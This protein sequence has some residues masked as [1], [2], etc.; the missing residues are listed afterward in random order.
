MKIKKEN[1]VFI[2]F[3]YLFIL[4]SANYILPLITLPYL[5]RV[6]GPQKF[7]LIAFS[8]SF[9]AYFQILTDYSFNLSATREIS[10]NK[11]NKEKISDIFSY[12]MITKFFLILISFTLMSLIVFM[13]KKFSEDWVVYYFTFGTVIG[14]A[15]FPTWFFQGME[16]MKYITFLNILSK[17]IFTVFIFIFVKKTSDYIYVPLISSLGFLVAGIL[18]IWIIFNNFNIKLKVND[19]GKIKYHLKEGWHL[20]VSILAGNLYTQGTVLIL[21]L[22]ST[23]EIVGYYTIAEKISRAV[24]NISQPVS[25]SIYPYITRMVNE[26]IEQFKLFYKKVF[27]YSLIFFGFVSLLLL[28]FSKNIYIIITSY[29]NNIGISS[30][31]ILAVVTFLISLNVIITPF[32]LALRQDKII[33]RMYVTVGLSFVFVCFLI[34]YLFSAIGTAISL[35]LVELSIFIGTLKIIR[36]GLSYERT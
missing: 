21:G 5:I 29:S 10:I 31:R 13:F 19:L 15:L 20:F 33:K 36:S 26:N 16:K 27:T 30:F 3:L 34:T 18:S 6:L 9:I 25:Q 12:V 35:L 4:Q 28:I 22:L 32:A 17:L 8:Q 2:N 14:Q 7:G 11:S 23:K 1:T 24:A